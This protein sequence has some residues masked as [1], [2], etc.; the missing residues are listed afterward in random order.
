MIKLIKPQNMIAFIV[1]SSLFSFPTISI[2]TIYV[3]GTAPF[4]QIFTKINISSIF[5]VIFQAYITTIFGYKIWNNLMKKYSAITVAPLSL[6][7]PISGMLCS[8]MF[9]DEKLT[10]I[11]IIAA[12]IIL[13]GIVLFFSSNSKKV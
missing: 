12:C 8:Y 6:I 4:L 7:V 11:E 2:M 1:W 5:L 9:F 10:Y 13:L 3:E